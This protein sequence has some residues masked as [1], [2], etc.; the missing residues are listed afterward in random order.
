VFSR[1]DNMVCH[2]VLAGEPRTDYV[3][4]AGSRPTYACASL[5]V[6]GEEHVAAWDNKR[7][8]ERAEVFKTQLPDGHDC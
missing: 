3:D 5:G 6:G 7:I 4:L 8:R 1:P 2:R